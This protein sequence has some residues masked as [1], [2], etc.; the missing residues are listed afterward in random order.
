M[1]RHVR[2]LRRAYE[3][4]CGPD[5]RDPAWTPAPLYGPA[6]TRPLRV[7]V[8]RDPG[9]LG[10]DRDV[11][12]AVQ[13]AAGAL[14][15]AGYQVEDA[16]PP[17]MDAYLSWRALLLCDVR[18]AWPMIE[19]LVSPEAARFMQ[20]LLG[21]EPVMDLGGYSMGLANRLGTARAWAQFQEERP[22]ILGP[23]STQQPFAVGRDLEGTE[24]VRAIADS[25]RVTVAVN[26]LGLPSVALPVGVAGGLP[27]GVQMIGPR[28]REDLCLEAAE[29]IETR[30]GVI[31][32]IEP[33]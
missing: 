27:Q 25:M 7:A 28:Y 29:A 10:V 30:R 24:A 19:A 4:I 16:E 21:L 8:L 23:V 13:S 31:T 6:P 1:A 12:A 33:R 5:S 2:D 32:P 17:V 20:A 22:L 15:D 18:L 14:A 26:N 3:V 9:G 11:A